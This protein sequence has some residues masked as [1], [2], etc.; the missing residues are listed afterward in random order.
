VSDQKLQRERWRLLN[1]VSHFL[2]P[3]MIPLGLLWLVLLIL[4]FTRGL[5]PTLALASKVIW[6]IFVADF[7]LEWIV[8]PKKLTY[9]K[10]HWLVAVSLLV[11]V[12]RIGRVARLL[13]LGR[14]ARG[15]RLVRTVG[16]FNRSMSALRRVMRRRGFGYVI[17][18]TAAVTLGGAAAMYA[19]ER[20]VPDPSGIHDFPTSLWW[21]LM[22]MTT[23]GS[24]YWPQTGEGRTLCVL[25]A[26]YAFSIFGYITATLASFFIDRDA[27]RPDASVA[28]QRELEKLREEIAG[29]RADL[30][31][32]QG[33]GVP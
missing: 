2:D 31:R 12:V 14:A 9:L 25:L 32:P 16:S 21:T 23:M 26:L 28:G 8:A 19:F 27:D 22:I 33:G 29:L 17:A 1:N 7:L 15:A 24:A 11:P 4:D 10:R 20:G 30:A 13:R 3:V 5:S 18:T 6:A